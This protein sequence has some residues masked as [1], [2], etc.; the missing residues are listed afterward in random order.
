[1]QNYKLNIIIFLALVHSSVVKSITINFA[2]VC[3]RAHWKTEHRIRFRLREASRRI[4]WRSRRH[5]G[6]TVWR[7]PASTQVRTQISHQLTSN[8]SI[9]SGIL[10][11]IL[12]NIARGL[13]YFVVFRRV[14]LI[15]LLGGRRL[16]GLEYCWKRFIFLWLINLLLKVHYFDFVW[17]NSCWTGREFYELA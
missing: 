16:S 13:D 10:L 5:I 4:I 6:F 17:P 14:V 8:T 15:Y 9:S 7:F 2:A 11:S 3:T 1:M 12:I